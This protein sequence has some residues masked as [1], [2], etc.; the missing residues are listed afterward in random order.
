VGSRDREGVRGAEITNQA[1]AGSTPGNRRV[2]T[3]PRHGAGRAGLRVLR[4]VLRTR[5]AP[6]GRGRLRVRRRV[7]AA[8]A[9]RARQRGLHR[10][11]PARAADA[12]RRPTDR[13]RREAPRGGRDPRSDLAA[14]DRFPRWGR[15]HAAGRDQQPRWSIGAH[16]PRRECGRRAPALGLGAGRAGRARGARQR[17]SHRRALADNDC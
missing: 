17:L 10:S 2:G 5:R 6:R 13:V 7:R 11:R 16:D 9:R 12:R 4:R 3:R 15:A 1:D 8:R 14:A